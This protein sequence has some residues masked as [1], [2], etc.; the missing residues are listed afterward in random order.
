MEV[1]RIE[2]LPE[3]TDA[4]VRVYHCSACDHEVRLTV[5]ATVT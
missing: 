4:D 1:A 5:W 2:R 3:G